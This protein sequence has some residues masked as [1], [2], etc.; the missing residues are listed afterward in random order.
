MSHYLI[1]FLLIKQIF[2]FYTYNLEAQVIPC[3]HQILE[4]IIITLTSSYH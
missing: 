4:S 1:Y 3:K 2:R